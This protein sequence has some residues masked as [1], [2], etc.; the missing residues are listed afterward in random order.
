[1]TIRWPTTTPCST[2]P[3]RRS[4]TVGGADIPGFD[5]DL[6]RRLAACVGPGDDFRT[7]MACHGS[8]CGDDRPCVGYLAQ[9]GY[10]NLAVRVMAM[11]GKVDLHAVVEACEGLDLWPSFA[12]MLAAYEAA[13]EA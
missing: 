12:E 5:L 11:Q 6:M 7:V 1:M 13:A 9:E 8:T 3:W 10:S 2:C 4:S